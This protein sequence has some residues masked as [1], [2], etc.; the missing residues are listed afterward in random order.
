MNFVPL[1]QLYFCRSP[2]F[3]ILD[4]LFFKAHCIL[5]KVTFFYL[6]IARDTKS[7]L[8][9]TWIEAHVVSVS[10]LCI[11]YQP[12]VNSRLAV[13]MVVLVVHIL[14]WLQMQSS[15]LIWRNIHLS[16]TVNIMSRSCRATNPTGLV[17]WP[18]EQ[19]NEYA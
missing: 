13:V 18:A 16:N 2:M 17:G 4:K 5:C 19:T 11:S 10:L 7:F 6:T 3:N 12:L 15:V 9:Y 14:S 8:F 1:M